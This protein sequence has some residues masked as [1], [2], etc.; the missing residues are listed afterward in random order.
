MFFRQTHVISKSPE[1]SPAKSG[2]KGI[3]L[4]LISPCTINITVYQQLLLFDS[5]TKPTSLKSFIDS[6]LLKALWVEVWGYMCKAKRNG[7]MLNK[8]PSPVRFSSHSSQLCLPNP[9][10]FQTRGRL[11]IIVPAVSFSLWGFKWQRLLV[12]G[13]GC[14]H[15]WL[16]HTRWAEIAVNILGWFACVRLACFL[17]I[18][19]GEI[20]LLLQCVRH[21]VS[22]CS[23]RLSATL[24]AAADYKPYLH[25]QTVCCLFLCLWPRRVVQC[26]GQCLS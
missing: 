15:Y 17:S 19:S 20:L 26:F 11:C 14:L 1:T 2:L 25:Q 13:T 21:H 4:H 16:G 5:Y 10:T 22:G 9:L 23:F 3:W 24:P 18:N 12:W 6:P 7:K 8:L